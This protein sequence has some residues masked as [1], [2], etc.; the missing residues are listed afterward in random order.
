MVDLRQVDQLVNHLQTLSLF[1]YLSAHTMQQRRELA[2]IAKLLRNH[3]IS[4]H[5]KK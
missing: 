1:V 4:Y 5:Y 3:L 2:T